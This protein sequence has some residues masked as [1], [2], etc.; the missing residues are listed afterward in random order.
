MGLAV[1][2]ASDG[3]PERAVRIAAAADVLADQA[4]VVVVH[5][6]GIGAGDRIEAL[7]ATFDAAH[8][9]SLT[10]EGRAMAPPEIIAMVRERTSR[11]QHSEAPNPD[12]HLPSMRA[13]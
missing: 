6:M 3:H 12:E 10:E 13:T 2:E 9:A 5:A 8:L 11:P 4:G 1:A 7:R